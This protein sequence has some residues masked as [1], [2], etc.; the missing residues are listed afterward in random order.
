MPPLPSI[1]I[2]DFTYILPDERIAKFPLSERSSSKFLISRDT[3][4]TEDVFYN[5]GN[6]LP[7]GALLVF[8]NTRVIHARLRFK[9]ESGAIIEVFCLEPSNHVSPEVSFRTT[10]RV[11]WNCLVGNLKKWKGD[12]LLLSVRVKDMDFYLEAR[13][14]QKCDDSNVIEF[15][16]SNSS[17]T[18]SEILEVVGELPIPPYLNRATEQVDEV[19]YNTVYAHQEGSVAAPTAGLHFTDDLL[20]SLE[21]KGVRKAFLTLH[22]G[23][24]TFK[25]VKSLQVADHEMH[26]ER[27]IVNRSFIQ[28]L[29]SQLESG[30]P[31]IAVGTTS[32]RTLESLYWLGLQLMINPQTRMFHIKQWEAFEEDKKIPA[33]D[34]FKSILH[35]LENNREDEVVGY[36]GIMIVP[37]YAFRVVD[38]LITNFHQPGSTLLLLIA[39]LIGDAWRDVYSYAMKNDFRFLSYG[40]SSL[41]WKR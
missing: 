36:T 26:E 1:Q 8:N 2:S 20:N 13:L 11:E 34:S 40:D 6:Y 12:V 31:V 3:S 18:F 38:A 33:I 15:S 41:L 21:E 7:A 29:I 28:N 27:F 4:I 14:K 17:V 30:K 19:R 10:G 16:W 24:G 35:Y 9:R 5:I 37:G 25:P 39:A 22:V 32:L 23:A